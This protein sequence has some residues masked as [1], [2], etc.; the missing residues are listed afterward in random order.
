MGVVVT[1]TGSYTSAFAGG[2]VAG[3][4]ALSIALHRLWP[5]RSRYGVRQLTV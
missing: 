3:V 5:I 2:A 1:V 4:L